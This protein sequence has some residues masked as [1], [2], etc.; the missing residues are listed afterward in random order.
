MLSKA[1]E[2]DVK[3]DTLSASEFT[4]VVES[5]HHD[6]DVDDLKAIYW[7]WAEEVLSKERVTMYDP[8]SG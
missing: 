8:V 7:A 5:I 1:T 2:K 4:V 3:G 6:D